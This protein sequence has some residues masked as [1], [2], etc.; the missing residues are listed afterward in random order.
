MRR[1][2]ELLLATPARLPEAEAARLEAEMLLAHVLGKSRSYLYTWPE[3]ELS[4]EQLATFEALVARREAGEPVAHI[5]GERGFW[6]LDLK[7][8]ADTLIP[9]PETELLVEAVLERLPDGECRILDLGTGSGAIALAI[10]HERPDCAVSAVERSEAALALARENA[11]RLGLRVEFIEGSWFEPI[12][13]RRFDIIVS[14]PPYICADDP[15]LSRGDVRFEPITALASGA[16]G[17]DDIRLII[18][19]ALTYLEGEGWLLLEHG[20]DQGEAVRKLLIDHGFKQVESLTDLEG[21]ERVS[22]GRA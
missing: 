14:N 3:H 13:D 1:I 7:V 19:Q 10:A 20:W 15:H 8:S 16:D 4:A 2:Q 22:L 18:K 11:Q 12:K 5:L 21:R 9:R 6:S 17:L